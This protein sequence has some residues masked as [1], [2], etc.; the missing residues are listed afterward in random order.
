LEA[1]EVYGFTNDIRLQSDSDDDSPERIRPFRKNYFLI[2]GN[3]SLSDLSPAAVNGTPNEDVELQF[4][5]SVRTLLW[6][7]I[8]DSGS[9]LNFG[10]TNK[11]FWQIASSSAPF[12][13]T[14][15]MPE[16]FLETPLLRDK[17][18]IRLAPFAHQSNGEGGDDSRSWNRYY[19]EAIYHSEEE[20]ASDRLFSSFV[21]KKTV[22]H[23]W[24][25]GLRI[26][27]VWNVDEMHNA[28]ILEYLG[29]F[30]LDGELRTTRIRNSTFSTMIRNNLR[31]GSDNRTTIGLE[32]S[33]DFIAETRFLVQFFS[34]YGLNLL[35]FDTHQ[36]SIGIG[37]ELST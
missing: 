19:L 36:Q 15:H 31:F 27:D 14:D 10:Y 16:L 34:G 22:P 24:N 23:G 25:V 26:W 7:D 8:C 13:T 32:W 33:L 3:Q 1:S 12:R 28:D 4:Q 37:F 6:G 20:S 17:W 9:S 21:T 18:V 2:V 29:H 11:S 5:L 35:D 30:Q